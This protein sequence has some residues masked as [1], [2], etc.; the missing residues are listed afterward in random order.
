MIGVPH[1]HKI[2]TRVLLVRLPVSIKFHDLRHIFASLALSK[3]MDVVRVSAM[4][5]HSSPATTLEVYSHAL[6]GHGKPV[7]AALDS[8]ITG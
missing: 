2:P 6:P 5:G 3:G 1:S 7:A 8:V 4:L